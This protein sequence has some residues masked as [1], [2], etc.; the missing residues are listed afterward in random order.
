MDFYFKVNS[1]CH[2]SR[3]K[4][5]E[6]ERKHLFYKKGEHDEINPPHEFGEES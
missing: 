4:I 3:E 6:W 5:R 1:V 2:P